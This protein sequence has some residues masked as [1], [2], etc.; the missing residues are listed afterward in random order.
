MPPVRRRGLLVLVL[1]LGMTAACDGQSGGT[2]PSEG[3]G[4]QRGPV[5]DPPD[6]PASVT[7]ADV[8][9]AALP[10]TCDFP[11]GTLVDG[12]LGFD[13]GEVPTGIS[14]VEGTVRLGELD[15]TDE[16]G[17]G[18]AVLSCDHGGVAWPHVVAFVTAEGEGLGSLM[19]SDV[20][21]HGRETVDD[22]WIDDGVVHVQWFA[23]TSDNDPHAFSPG[24]ASATLRWDGTRVVAEDV[25]VRGVEDAWEDLRAALESGDPAQVHEVAGDRFADYDLPAL[26]DGLDT[27]TCAEEMSS[28]G[29]EPLGGCSLTS[30]DDPEAFVYLGWQRVGWDDWELVEVTSFWE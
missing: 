14:V 28:T 16:G 29:P 2:N 20:T 5:L 9:S 1:A 22:L 17:D 18:V 11:A 19:L 10:S 4:T 8:L 27:V 6:A 13:D 7:E 30:V 26:L 23:G 21:G 15:G 24:S 3:G 25:E 12:H